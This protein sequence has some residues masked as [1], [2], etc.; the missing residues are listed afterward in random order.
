MEGNIWLNM[1]R[2]RSHQS[3]SSILFAAVAEIPPGLKIGALPGIQHV[4]MASFSNSRRRVDFHDVHAPEK[5]RQDSQIFMRRLS[6]V[7][8]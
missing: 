3:S 8:L 6:A 7:V 5:G 1:A 4:L 2:A